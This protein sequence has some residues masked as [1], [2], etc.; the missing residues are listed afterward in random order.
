M[1][2][3]RAGVCRLVECDIGGIAVADDVGI[4]AEVGCAKSGEELRGDQNR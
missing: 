1:S 4:G 2:E 3:R